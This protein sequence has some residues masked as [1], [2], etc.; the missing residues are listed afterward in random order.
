[1]KTMHELFDG[2]DAETLP[3]MLEEAQ[4]YIA[5]LQKTESTLSTEVLHEGQQH[6]HWK[7]VAEMRQ[8]ALDEANAHI[9]LL[10]ANIEDARAAAWRLAREHYEQRGLAPEPDGDGD[11][12]L[13]PLDPGGTERRTVWFKSRA[14]ALAYAQN[15]GFFQRPEKRRVWLDLAWREEW[16]LRVPLEET[17]PTP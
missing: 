1:M 7:C 5:E 3:A 9:Q 4:I 11:T 12:R 15:H 6:R 8:D 13:P 17:K 14:D 2:S 16:S 10:E